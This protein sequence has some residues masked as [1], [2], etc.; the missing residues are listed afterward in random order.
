MF[1]KGKID[2]DGMISETVRMVQIDKDKI[3]YTEN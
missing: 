3:K 1:I 2:K